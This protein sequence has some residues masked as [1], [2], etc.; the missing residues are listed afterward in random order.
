MTVE[1][2]MREVD[3]TEYRYRLSLL[4]EV[5]IQHLTKATTSTHQITSMKATSKICIKTWNPIMITMNISIL[6]VISISITPN[7][8]KTCR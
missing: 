6:A 8:M 1:I 3:H 2:K 7:F 5:P 4:T